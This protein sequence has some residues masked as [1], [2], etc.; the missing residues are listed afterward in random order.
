M[1]TPKPKRKSRSGL[2]DDL[3]P[4]VPREFFARPAS[5]VA[6][7]LLGCV[8]ARRFADGAIAFAEIVETE[9]YT[10]PEDLASHAQGGRRTARNEPMWARPGTAYV[11]LSYG[12]HHCFN[13][14]CEREGHPGAVLL[15]A[16]RIIHGEA[17]IRA[18]RGDGQRAAL[19]NPNMLLR[20]PGNLAKGLAIDRSISGVDLLKYP[21]LRVCARA[22]VAMENPSSFLPNRIA[23][24][25]RIGI[26][27][28]GAWRDAPLRFWIVDE[29]A[30]SGAKAKNRA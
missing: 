24:G 13:I 30:V 28:A 21:L 12:I 6:R 8:L 27:N 26:P 15:R 10:G 16:A 1:G 29:P 2:D 4:S 11:Y 5:E 19:I 14:A 7:A 22:S 3:P 20:G 17:A 25:P 18:A 23:I 9:A